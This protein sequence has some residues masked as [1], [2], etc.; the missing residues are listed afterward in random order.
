MG[1]QLSD[2]WAPAG[3]AIDAISQHSANQ[4]NRK[5]AREQMA[6]QERMSGTE[7]QRRVRDLQAAG[8]NPMLAIS[9]GGASSAAGATT[10]VEPVTRNP[11]SSALAIQTQRANLENLAQQTL[12]LKAQERN[13]TENTNMLP[14]TANKINVETTRIEHEIANLAKQFQNL[15]Q[16]YDINEEDLRTKR[17]NNK[18]LEALQPLM[19]RAQQL[20]NEAKEL[21]LPEKRVDAAWFENPFA[22]GSRYTKMMQEI[23]QLLRYSK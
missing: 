22:G 5:I 16:Q 20:E 9:Q 21:G 18:Q 19:I 23:R 1:F 2:I 6:F 10:R 7:M 14:G 8:L 15:Q 17:L 11:A 3:M 4:T 12:L 13:V